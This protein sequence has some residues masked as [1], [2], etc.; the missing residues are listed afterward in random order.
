MPFDQP[1]DTA[2]NLQTGTGASASA[3]ASTGADTSSRLD[4]TGTAVTNHSH[5]HSHSHISH[6]HIS[7]A[8]CR[9]LF[10]AAVS[11]PSLLDEAAVGVARASLMQKLQSQLNP[12]IA[13]SMTT[14]VPMLLPTSLSHH[15]NN[16]GVRD[17]AFQ[18]RSVSNKLERL[19]QNFIILVAT[20]MFHLVVLETL[21]MAAIHLS[22]KS[23]PIDASV[24]FVKDLNILSMVKEKLLGMR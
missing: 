2:A 24:V 6:S 7:D 3:S 19:G 20:F 16:Q 23:F 15:N 18:E 5:S 1:S 14:S 9:A 12:N 22:T 21:M 13:A 17:R 10:G 8:R 4:T 11:S